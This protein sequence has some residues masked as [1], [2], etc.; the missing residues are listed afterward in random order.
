MAVE[1]SQIEGNNICADCGAIV[2]W[3]SVNLGILIC[4]N[5]AGVHR[6]LGVQ[7]SFVLSLTLDDW[8]QEQKDNIIA[9]GNIKQNQIYE[10]NLPE[11]YKISESAG[12]NER[13]LFIH[14]KYI[15]KEFTE[16][17]N[18]NS[19]EGYEDYKTKLE[20]LPEDSGFSKAQIEYCG[21]VFIHL[22]EGK[23]LVIKDI[24]S[25]DPYCIVKLGAQTRK[26]ERKDSTLN[27]KWDEKIQFNMPM[28]DKI[29][30]ITV[31]DYDKISKDDFMG[32]CE[33]D[34]SDLVEGTTKEFLVD[35][36][37]VKKGK[38]RLSAEL[39]SL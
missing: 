20:N 11:E 15:T 17:F 39:F 10:F 14:S 24:K 27:P 13:T 30:K 35:L 19:I 23:N 7:N 37:N 26:S 6:G 31:M 34:L 4:H 8:E 18:P 1:L 12:S 29:L 16:G 32:D 5:C 25:S 38:I 2:K 3:A 33:V 21:V 9:L 36:Q 22:I 28:V